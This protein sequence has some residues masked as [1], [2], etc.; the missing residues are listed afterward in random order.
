MLL[1]HNGTVGNNTWLGYSSLI[2]GDDSPVI[3]PRN[4]QMTE[5]TFS[6]KNSGAD[7]TLEFYKNGMTSSEKFLTIAKTNTQYFFQN[8]LTYTFNAGDLIF[9]KYIDN[10]NNA[11]DA[12]AV[13]YFKSV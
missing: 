11:S 6:N 1:Q 10:G 2:P 3:M 12:V 5:F 9:V 8:G 7:Y 4:C 13:M